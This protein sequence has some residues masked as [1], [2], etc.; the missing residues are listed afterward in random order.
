MAYFVTLPHGRLGQDLVG[1]DE[2]DGQVAVVH[3][4]GDLRA[5]QDQ[6]L[7]PPGHQR[8]PH[9]QQQILGQ[10]GL[11]ARLHPL[12]PVDGLHHLRHFV[13]GRLHR[14]Q[15]RRPQGILIQSHGNR[16][17]GGHDPHPRHR[18]MVPADG[19]DRLGDHVEHGNL[20]ARLKLRPIVMRRV[21]GDGDQLRAHAGQ[22]IQACLHRRQRVWATVQNGLGSVGDGCVVEDQDG[23][24]LLVRLSR[25]GPHNTVE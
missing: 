8:R 18:W 6:G 12:L 25:G 20:H 4:Q 16:A 22:Q 11:E 24:M 23:K 14:R 2:G 3:G 21:A 13:G 10:P 1:G 19:L 9:A 15:P 7:G 5:A 17:A